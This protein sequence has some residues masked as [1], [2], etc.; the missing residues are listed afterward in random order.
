[1]RRARF[2]VHEAQ[3]KATMNHAPLQVRLVEDNPVGD[4]S[5]LELS[6]VLDAE[7]VQALMDDF[8]RIAPLPMGIIDLKGAV[9][10]GVGWQKICTHFHRVHPETCRHCTESDLYLTAGIPS[11]ESRLYKCRN[12]MWDI[13]TPIHV[14]GKHLGNIF[15]GQFFFDDE[16]VDE[17]VFRLQAHRY[18]FDEHGYLSA[19]AAVPRL[20]RTTVDA[21][22]SFF[23]KLAKMLS[24]LGYS[25]VK[26]A[27]ALAERAG[28]TSS[29]R[30][31]RQR[32]QT[33]LNSVI[34]GY[35][36]LD[37]Q[38]RFVALTPAAEQHFG[39]AA[40]ELIGRNIWEVAG[41]PPTSELRRRFEEDRQR[42]ADAEGQS[43]PRVRTVRLRISPTHSDGRNQV[44]AVPF[45]TA[46]A[47]GRIDCV[48]G[49][50]GGHY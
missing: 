38:W 40:A 19:L 41:L 25:N 27:S 39:Q 18:G 26:L 7:S 14:A 50:R 23:I 48:G 16:A 31:S 2:H 13:A 22:M 44:G 46:P 1:M 33:T 45:D 6:D 12:G 30:D 42:V 3:A 32:L 47:G 43:A 17:E 34:G 8:H 20:S 29:L 10:V 15:S 21:G 49:N 35:Y 5:T 11:G 28:L 37:E 4:I 9:L 36:A 24:Q